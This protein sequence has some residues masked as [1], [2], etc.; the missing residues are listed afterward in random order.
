MHVN[1]LVFDMVCIYVKF[2]NKRSEKNDTGSPTMDKKLL[3][4]G[5]PINFKNSLSVYVLYVQ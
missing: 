2:C 4:T 1:D 3:G 5:R